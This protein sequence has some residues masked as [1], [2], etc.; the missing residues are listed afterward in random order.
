MVV[1]NKM[2]ITQPLPLRKHKKEK[3]KRRRKNR[4]DGWVDR[5]TSGEGFKQVGQSFFSAPNHIFFLFPLF[6]CEL[7][8]RENKEKGMERETTWNGRV[9]FSG[10]E[11]NDE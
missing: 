5:R 4:M 2:Q 8:E 3:N 6:S 11:A 10:G 7:E 1:E 9:Y